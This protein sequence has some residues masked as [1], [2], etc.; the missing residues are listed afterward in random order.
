ML[1]NILVT[2][3]PSVYFL[4]NGKHHVEY[5]I[6]I[7]H[8]N[9]HFTS[10]KVLWEETIGETEVIISDDGR[11]ASWIS[12]ISRKDRAIKW[13]QEDLDYIFKDVVY[14]GLHNPSKVPEH[15]RVT[16]YSKK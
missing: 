9:S 6:H 1:N 3:L 4:K 13:S 7:P 10:L 12:E 15:L 2:Q 16:P 11:T 5:F 14:V 8:W